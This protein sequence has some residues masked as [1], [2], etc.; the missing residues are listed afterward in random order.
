MP[1]CG[2]VG[3]LSMRAMKNRFVRVI[4]RLLLAGAATMLICSFPDNASAQQLATSRN[5]RIAPSKPQ[6]KVNKPKSVG[7]ILIDVFQ[8]FIVCPAIG[9][10]PIR[11]RNN[12]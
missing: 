8:E 1:V 2:S 6:E 9:C 4:R 11:D 10:T 12:S 5:S 7:Q 3:V